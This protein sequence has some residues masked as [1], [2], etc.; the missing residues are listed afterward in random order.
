M[1]LYL[2]L[3]GPSG[4]LER[5]ISQYAAEVLPG[6]PRGVDEV[7]PDKALV[8]VGDMGGYEA[9]GYIITEQEFATWAGRGHGNPKTWLLMERETA[10]GLCPGAAEDR[11]Y[12]RSGLKRDAEA[13][14]HADN[15]I[16]V[17]RV[18]RSGLRR[19]VMLLREY[20]AVLRGEQPGSR[21]AKLLTDLR[22][23]RI[24]AADLDAIAGDLESWAERDWVAVIDLGP[25]REHLAGPLPPLPE[26]GQLR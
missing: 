5:L 10:D 22:C 4:K 3:P 20:A 25:D 15:L 19:D 7:P 1:T 24:A 2:D 17:A 16:L 12:R 21:P 23:Q 14:A 18:S 6:P 26:A 9:A 11:A 8:C 13:A